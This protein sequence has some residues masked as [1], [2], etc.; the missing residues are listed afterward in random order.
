[1]AQHS[2]KPSKKRKRNRILLAVEIVCIII[3]LVCV[4]L[5]ANELL[6]YHVANQD[7]DQVTQETQR[8]TEK[9]KQFNGDSA[10]WIQVD[11]TRIDYPVMYT[12][13]D[14]EY[15]L[16]R[17]FKKE[18]SASGTPFI[19]EGSDP[20]ND[21]SNSM[22]IYAHHM[23]DGSMFGELEKF[24]NKE[25]A[26]DKVIEYTD[27][28][29][30]HKYRV[31]GAFYVDLSSGG[32]YR[33]WDEVG[34]LSKKKF[35]NLVKTISEKSLYSTKYSASY[36]DKILMLSTCSYGTSEQRFVVFGVE[37]GEL[38]AEEEKTSSESSGIDE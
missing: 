2:K 35:K 24:N 4:G 34:V 36:G 26:E 37:E 21:E 11:D 33:Y 7:F 32:Y 30:K 17:N 27:N 9:L 22:V 16:H 23:R 38:A 28:N 10:G 14:P 19:G 18:Y 31:F 1:M 25:W 3:A 8:D 6:K 13:K 5:I 20:R 15:Y 29:G 12:P